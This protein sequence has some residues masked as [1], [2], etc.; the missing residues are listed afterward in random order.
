M[1]ALSRLIVGIIFIAGGVLLSIFSFFSSFVFLIYSLPMIALGIWMLSNKNEDNIE[2][3]K[4]LN[5]KETK[6]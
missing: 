6:K 1:V 2:Q 4:D 3:R 5:K